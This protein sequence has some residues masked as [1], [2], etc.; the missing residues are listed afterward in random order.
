MENAK[1]YFLKRNQFAGSVPVG[2]PPTAPKPKLPDQV[3]QAIQRRHY[4]DRTETAYI[5]WIKRYI[6]FHN[7]RH[8]KE[9]REVEIGRFPIELATSPAG[10]SAFRQKIQAYLKTIENDP[11]QPDNPVLD[12]LRNILPNVPDD[13]RQTFL[14]RRVNIGSK[15]QMLLHFIET[16]AVERG[17][18]LEQEVI[19]TRFKKDFPGLKDAEIYYR[20][21]QLRLLGFIIKEQTDNVYVHRY[22][23]S[24]AYRKE[25]GLQP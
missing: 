5:H 16:R 21:E 20:L 4:S 25:M 3:R 1:I 8:P 9:M 15:Q 24:P 10:I 14:A 17:V 19:N 12:V 6:F 22:R 2:A 7:K 13:L 23:L 11:E 18:S